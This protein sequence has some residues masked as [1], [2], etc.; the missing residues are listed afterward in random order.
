[1]V[2]LIKGPS[3]N[4]INHLGRG[5]GSFLPNGDVTPYISLFS[6]MGDKGEGGVT[7]SMDGTSKRIGWILF[8]SN[9]SIQLFVPLNKV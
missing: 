7:K 9:A 4:D 8:P 6:K 2:L 3:I 5:R 1:M